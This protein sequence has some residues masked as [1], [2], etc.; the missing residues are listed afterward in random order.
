MKRIQ[1]HQITMAAV[2]LALVAVIYIMV[3]QISLQTVTETH[4]GSSNSSTALMST[5]S[6]QYSLTSSALS[7][8]VSSLNT[9]VEFVIDPARCGTNCTL[10]IQWL[11]LWPEYQTLTTL[12]GASTAVVVANVTSSQ[13][14]SV[15]GVPVTEYHVAVVSDIIGTTPVIGTTLNVAQ[16]V[17]TSGVTM[18]LEGYPSLSI[19]GTYALFLSS[20]VIHSTSSGTEST[21]QGVPFG[22]Y[23]RA[24]GNGNDLVTV[25]GPQGLF[26]VSGGKVF[27]LDNE[28]PQ[29]DAWLQVKANGVP[30]AQFIA[31]VRAAQT[32]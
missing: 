29:D 24:V 30:L 13:T 14:S 15:N 16:I 21:V 3:S 28:F 26:Y 31:E 12:I 2:L 1:R 19:G 27:S 8:Q 6:S 32:P 22:S 9:S 10:N 17:G 18:N 25:G 5:S 7:T 20:T 11:S 4:D 23:I